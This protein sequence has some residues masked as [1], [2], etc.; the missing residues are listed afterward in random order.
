MNITKETL[1]HRESEPEKKILYLVGT[2]IGNI[3][4]ISKRAL[5]IL[6]NVSLIACEDTRTTGKLLRHLNISNKLIS[7][8]R[9]NSIS[10]L[11]FII[12]KLNS[13]ESI[14]L[15]TDAGMPLIS[16]PGDILVKTA[17]EKNIEVICIPGPCAA[18]TALVSSGLDNSKFALVCL[19]IYFQEINN[20][21]D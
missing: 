16:D 1:S 12:S 7:F 15:V 9:H 4:D 17:R 13:G 10:K 2:P 11:D 18:L 21:C 3:N 14:A 19:V 20:L 5:N 6:K 8:H